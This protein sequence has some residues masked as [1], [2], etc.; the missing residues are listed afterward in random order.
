MKILVIH[1]S[2]GAGHLKAAEAVYNGI[3]K[4]TDHD[5]VLVDALDY[6]SYLFQKL[7]KQTYFFLISK[8][9]Y[10]WGFFFW[11]L[12]LAWLQPLIRLLRRIQNTLN[13]KRLHRFMVEERFD[14]IVMTHFMPTEIAAALKRSGR[15]S[16]TLITVITDFDVHRIWLAEGIDTY[17]VA[18]DWTKEKLKRIGIA[19]EQILSSGIPTDE[20]FSVLVD[21]SALKKKLGLQEDVFTVLVATGSFGIGPIEEIINTLEGFQVLVVCGHNV[22]LYQKLSAKNLKH[23]HVLGLVDNMHELM[24]VSDAMVTKPGGL[25]I[26]EALV[27]Q[28]PLIFFNAIPGQETGNIRVLKE[29]GIGISGCHVDQICGELQKMKSSKDAFLTILKRTKAL[30]RPSAV[31]VIISLIQ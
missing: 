7:Y 16:S 1:A 31:N 6:S 30:A 24:A 19:S 5:V 10:M 4:S 28:L 21:I 12:D 18:S 26:S 13:T 17:T 25:S 20:K 15:I 29:H 23:I 9:P 22:G 14:Y 11:I 2:A 27:S 8:T 3:K